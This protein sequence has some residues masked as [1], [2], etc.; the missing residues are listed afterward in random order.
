[1]NRPIWET[2]IEEANRKIKDLE[3]R[4]AILENVLKALCRRCPYRA[5]G[6]CNPDCP[7]YDYC[8]TTGLEILYSSE[9]VIYGEKPQ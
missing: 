1:M 2:R 4:N 3:R 9:T 8:D 5:C 7:A 6:F